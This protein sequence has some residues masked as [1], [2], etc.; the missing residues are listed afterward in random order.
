MNTI[1]PYTYKSSLTDTVA[2]TGVAKGYYDNG[3][4]GHGNASG[5]DLKFAL[6]LFG[7]L[8]L[9]AGASWLNR[10]PALP[11]AYAGPDFD[12]EYQECQEAAQGTANKLT[13]DVNNKSL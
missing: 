7:L 2:T 10:K 11:E 5:A 3:Y 9:Y 12:D 13:K 6:I 4:T 1:V 8:G